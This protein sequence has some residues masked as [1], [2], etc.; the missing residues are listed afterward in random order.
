MKEA[1]ELDVER[2]LLKYRPVGPR[3][4]L[5]DNVLSKAKSM[6]ERI[7]TA[8]LSSEGTIDAA[9]SQRSPSRSR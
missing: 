7:S 1:K 8:D 4:S 3:Q 2:L 6:G 5:R 9:P